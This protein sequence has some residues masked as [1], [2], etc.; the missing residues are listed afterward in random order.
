[1]QKEA[2][3]T[4]L[5]LLPGRVCHFDGSEYPL[6]IK[7]TFLGD[8]EIDLSS[9]RLQL[10]EKRAC[11]VKELL[12]PLLLAAEL[13]EACREDK[14]AFFITDHAV[15]SYVFTGSKW[16]AG[17][18]LVL[19][20]DEQTELVEKLKRRN[21][22][23]FTDQPDIP[24]TFHIG[25]RDTSPIYF[26]QMM[27]R[28]GLVWGRICPG[29]DHEMGHFLEKDMPGFIIIYENL[30]PLKYLVALGLMKL[31]APAVVPPIFPFAY[32]KWVAAGGID[33][34]VHQG[35]RFPNLRTRYYKDGIISL[36]DFC[37]PAFANE[38]VEGGRLYGGGENSFF[39]LRPAKQIERA[40]NVIG[41]PVEEIGIMVEIEHEHLSDDLALLIEQT[42]LKSIS[43]LPGV[44]AG[45]E[46]G[47]FFLRTGGG[48]KLDSSRI[49]E[50]VYWGI[51]LKYPRLEK[52]KVSFIYDL[53]LL[54]VEADEIRRY[55]A[56]RRGN[57]DKMTE[58]NTDELCMCTE[59]RPFSLEHTCIL[60]PDRIPMCASRSYFSVKASAYFGLSRVPYQ[61]QREK[62]LPLKDVF[63]KGKVLDPQRGEYEGSN[64]VY[65]KLTGGKLQRVYLHS[66]RGYPHTSC[67]CF[68]NLAFWIEEVKGIGIMSRNSA[69]AA[70]NGQ[71]WEMLA[72]RAGGKQSEGITGVSFSYICSSNFLKGD[73][74]IR[75][76]VW[77]NSGLYKKISSRFLPGQKVATE[78]DMRTV[79]ELREFLGVNGPP[80]IKHQAKGGTP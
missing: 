62:D 42:A 72:N 37:N 10:T 43:F 21:F 55:K 74:G 65:R 73:G 20:G 70:P 15:Q 57:V 28:Y 52:I 33:E 26:L 58:E 64:E 27:V 46:R 41:I 40:V 79:E 4:M 7:A 76:V 34:I 30:R 2:V 77:V 5:R 75:N 48:I 56:E 38:K 17:W 16:K 80:R 18:V 24:D 44:E 14:S 9:L 63:K 12:K 6:P 53:D 11:D 1:M 13:Y 68:Q 78:K 22:V 36:P 51:R 35:I 50:T 47:V 29:D 59:C 32:G 39:C 23:V 19:G 3:D 49:G 8:N 67:G 31:G 71:T 60:T 54:K 66:L 61:R 25:N 45:E 69:A